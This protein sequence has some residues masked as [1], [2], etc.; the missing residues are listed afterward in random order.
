[1]SS[2]RCPNCKEKFNQITSNGN[3]VTKVEDKEPSPDDDDQ[4]AYSCHHCGDLIDVV[5]EHVFCDFCDEI[6]VH[7]TCN[8]LHGDEPDEYICPACLE[9][10]SDEDEDDDDM[11]E[12]QVVIQF[13]RNLRAGMA[14]RDSRVS[15][16]NDQNS[17]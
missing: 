9:E 2:N 14:I 12:D 16:P 5:Q 11:L 7:R 15:N 10:L 17:I 13:L 6:A 4:G 1:M 8:E 3:E